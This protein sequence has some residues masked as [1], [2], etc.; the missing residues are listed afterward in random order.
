M[1]RGSARAAVSIVIDAPSRV[2]FQGGEQAHHPI[3]RRYGVLACCAKRRSACKCPGFCH[4][5]AIE[6]VFTVCKYEF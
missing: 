3:D 2:G 4:S 6:A 5:F 1:L